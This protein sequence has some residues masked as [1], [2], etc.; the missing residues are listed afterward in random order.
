MT[1]TSSFPASLRPLVRP[2][3]ILGLATLVLHLAAAGGYGFFR[4]E[5]YFIVCGQRLAWGYVDQ[6]PLI[7]LISRFLWQAGGGSLWVFQLCPAIVMAV[8]VA[9]TAEFAAA[10]GGGVFAQA[11]AGLCAFGAPVLLI[12][13]TLLTTDLL[14]PLT[15]MGCAWCLVKLAQTG[16]E[17]W[18]LAF[19]AF[20]GVSVLGK[21]L[22]AFF[23]AGIFVGILATPL[24]RSFL[25]P[26][27]W[28]GA[29]LALV[30]VSPNLL[31]QYQHG[32]PFAELARAG[33]EWKNRVLPPGAYLAQEVLMMGPLAAPVWILGLWAFGIRPKL[34]AYRAFAV[35]WVVVV[36]LAI[37]V[38]GKD[39]YAAPLYPILLAGGGVW[40]EGVMKRTISRAA[41]AGALAV[42]SLF[43][44]PLG[45]P[46]LPVDSFI[47]FEQMLHLS[48]SAGTSERSALGEL[49]QY[50]ADQFGWREMAEKVA[51]VY[52]ALPPADQ[53]QAVFF[54]RNY[55]EAAAID[56]FGRPLGLPPAISGHNNYYLWGPM[57]HNANVVIVAGG[58]PDEYRAAYQDVTVAGRI[59][60]PY[61]MPYETN[62]PVYV[63]RGLKVPFNWK[64]LKHFE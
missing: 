18:W 41:Y 30:I 19:G 60:N 13:G 63:L 28:L 36:A 49:P 16:N 38:H 62:I 17:K 10:L 56:M 25:K 29:L 8:T 11:L 6:P 57:G 24:R 40:L 3:V 48:S 5:L 31:W 32:W 53:A 33:V 46:I 27:L 44:A 21:Y 35:A 22:F 26:W 50:Y 59:D 39:Y 55:G 23:L 61:A 2:S 42:L 51:A 9:L 7:P 15:W 37:L 47:R 45:V 64:G 1:Q 34:A 20:A 4:D 58:K 43:F 14:Q 52:H 12:D 54:G